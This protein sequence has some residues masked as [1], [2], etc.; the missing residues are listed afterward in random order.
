MTT[1]REKQLLTLLLGA[2]LLFLLGMAWDSKANRSDVEAIARD[3][4]DV[5][6][7]V[8]KSQPADSKCAEFLP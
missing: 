6:Y 5:K 3:L 4:Q 2:G 7:L 1:Q 8:C